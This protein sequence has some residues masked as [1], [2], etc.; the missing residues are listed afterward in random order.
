M[1][2]LFQVTAIRGK[3]MATET[4]DEFKDVEELGYGACPVHLKDAAVQAEP[5]RQ[6]D[7]V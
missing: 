1:V 4:P 3:I 2:F 7:E 6:R 5:F